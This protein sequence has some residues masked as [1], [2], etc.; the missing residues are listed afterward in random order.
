MT[1]S[2]LGIKVSRARRGRSNKRT[3]VLMD[4]HQFSIQRQKELY[5]RY[6][7]FPNEFSMIPKFNGPQLQVTIW[8]EVRVRAFR[9]F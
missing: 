5:V 6:V 1:R 3:R 7:V 9:R 2:C 4:K 8:Y